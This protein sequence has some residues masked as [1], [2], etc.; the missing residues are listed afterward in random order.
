M[1]RYFFDLGSGHQSM[2]DY[3]GRELATPEAACEMAEMMALDLA[4]DG[5]WTGWSVAVL[6]PEGKRFFSIPVRDAD[7]V[8]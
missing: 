6:S 8:T 2:Y 3:Q 5:E 4:L 7:L 1:K